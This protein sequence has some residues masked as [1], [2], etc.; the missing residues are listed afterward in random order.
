MTRYV[1]VRVWLAD[2]PGSLGQLASKIGEVGGD[3]VGIDILER[4]GA[5]AVD[6]L[7][8]ELP[9][10]YSPESLADALAELPGVEVE[11]LRHLVSRV[12]YSGRDPL[13]AAVLLA[14]VIGASELLGVLAQGICAAFA[15]DWST[16][17]DMGSSPAVALAVAGGPPSAA[18]LGA[19]VA[20]AR[21]GFSHSSSDGLGLVGPRDVAWAPL[22]ASDVVVVAG[23][24]GPPFRS[25][26]RRQLHQLC[27]VGNARWRAL[28][29]DLA[30]G[31]DS[32][33][34][35]QVRDGSLAAF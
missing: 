25:R 9:E 26:E 34:G 35:Q 28:T 20:G 17:L 27:R 6:E 18:W 13:D 11:D 8:V 31:L 24:D 5:R 12:P 7:T 2:R 32:P 19:F 30:R 1:V 33:G 23:R 29:G 10:G 4:D 22:D 16:V 14:E 3:L 21:A 15:C